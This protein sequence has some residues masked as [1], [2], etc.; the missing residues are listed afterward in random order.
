MN[1]LTKL[2]LWKLSLIYRFAIYCWDIYWKSAPAVELP[3]EVIS[4]G[5]I[6]AGGTG[7]TPLVIYLA[8]LAA[9]TGYKTAVVARGYKRQSKKLLKIDEDSSWQDVGDEPLEVYNSTEN[10][11]IY[12]SRSKTEAA[13]MAAKDGAEL[14]IV[15][16]GFQ[17]RKLHRAIDIVCL[18]WN[19]PLGPGG[20]LPL[21]LLREPPES[22]I[23]ADIIVYTSYSAGTGQAADFPSDSQAIARFWSGSDIAEFVELRSKIPVSVGKFSGKK[24]LVFCGLA[25]PGKFETSLRKAGLADFEMMAFRDHH[26]Y[27]LKDIQN[28]FA[29]A[30]SIGAEYLLTTSKDVVKI[31]SFD[32]SKFD[33]YFTRQEVSIIDMAGNDKKE[34]FRKRLGL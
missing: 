27:S 4:V 19:E 7:K 16:D 11:E 31:E 32:F 18:D 9:K 6:V 33:L 25:N 29:K 20:M 21:G 30:E 14:I 12:V 22:L 17:H 23:R 2:I 34:E 26:S 8:N 15:D 28:I 24:V 3:C 5:N 10:V 13:I 1:W